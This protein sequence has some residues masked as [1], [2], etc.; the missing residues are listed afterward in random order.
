MS[1][2]VKNLKGTSD[3]SCRCGTWLRH[4]ER[5]SGRSAT[6]CWVQG[7]AKPPEVGAHVKKVGTFDETRYI[8]PMCQ[9]HNMIDGNLLLSD[10][11]PLVPSN[12]QETCE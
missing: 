12:K 2:T 1:V 10:A 7:C 3:L 9:A 8:V 6:V 4:W 11:A 5:G